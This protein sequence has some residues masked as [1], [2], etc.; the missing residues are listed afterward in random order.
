MV[1]KMMAMDEVT[2]VNGRYRVLHE[3]GPG[4]PHGRL[5]GPL[6]EIFRA[7]DVENGRVVALKRFQP[8]FSRDARFAVR[9]RE[10]LKRLAPIRH[11]ALV[12][13]V[14]YGFDGDCFFIASEWVDGLNL[15]TYLA[16]YGHHG[17][18]AFSPE[19][20][21][22]VAR[23]VCGALGALHGAGLIHRGLKPE[24]VFI[25]SEEGGVRVSDATL[26][27]LASESGLS[28]TNVMMGS[29]AYMSPEQAR[30][31]PVGPEADIYSLG[32]MLFEM[33]TDELPFKAIDSWSLI[34]MHAQAA[35]PS[36]RERNRAV[37]PELAAIVRKALQKAPEERFATV[38]AF[39]AALAPLPQGDDLLWLVA[40]RAGLWSQVRGSAGRRLAEPWSRLQD[41]VRQKSLPRVERG[42]VRLKEAVERRAAPLWERGREFTF[43]QLLLITFALTFIIAFLLI[44]ALSGAI[45]D[46]REDNAV[47]GVD[48]HDAR[49]AEIRKRLQTPLPVQIATPTLAPTTLFVQATPTVTATAEAT[50]PAPPVEAL[51]ETGGGGNGPAQDCGPPPHAGGNGPPP[52]AGGNGRPPHAGGN[53]PPPHAGGRG[54]P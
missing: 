2:F 33:L 10:Q 12:S 48:E 9:F 34:R 50:A 40:P 36:A 45:I 54:R 53:G 38:E 21:V 27:Q 25:T 7:W 42:Y 17:G 30:G 8:R 22:Y 24:N 26:G 49:R 5:V 16:E 41:T 11:A 39:D 3:D 28:R 32:V 37:S 47:I 31:K 52:H 44:Y 18:V 46:A 23:Q 29:V 14:D 1:E 13:I 20:A 19:A 43:G 6:G 15:G 35:P 4:L 51:Q